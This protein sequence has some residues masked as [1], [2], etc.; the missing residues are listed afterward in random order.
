MRLREQYKLQRVP[1]SPIE[2]VEKHWSV[3]APPTPHNE[4]LYCG[5]VDAV[6][7]RIDRARL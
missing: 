7:W 6:W 3:S 5:F 1:C 2:R 4:F